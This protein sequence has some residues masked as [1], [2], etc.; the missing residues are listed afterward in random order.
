MVPSGVSDMYTLSRR[1]PDCIHM[2]GW[3]RGVLVWVLKFRKLGLWFMISGKETFIPEMGCFPRGA[4]REEMAG[5]RFL[6]DFGS[7]ATQWLDK[8]I[9]RDVSPI[10]ARFEGR[11]LDTEI[12]GVPFKSKN[13]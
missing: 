3:V 10:S 7:P 2:F 11:F 8:I 6:L 5:K 13:Q 9:H 4:S 1:L 12:P